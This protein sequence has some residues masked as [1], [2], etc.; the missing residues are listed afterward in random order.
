MRSLCRALLVLDL[1][2]CTLATLQ[3]GLPGWHMFESVEELDHE[4]LDRDGRAVDIRDWLPRRVNLVDRH[5]LRNIVEFVCQ[6]ERQRAPFTYAEPST[7]LRVTLGT[8][9]TGPKACTIHAHR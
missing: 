9:G 7:G 4:L 1:L 6:K 5:E 2:Y 3:E 8:E